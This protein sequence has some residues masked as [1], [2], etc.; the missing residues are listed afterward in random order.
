ME[1]KERERDWKPEE[2][3]N[4]E[5]EE[6]NRLASSSFLRKKE[7]RRRKKNQGANDTLGKT[8]RKIPRCGGVFRRLEKRLYD[9]RSPSRGKI[10]L[11]APLALYVTARIRVNSKARE[12]VRFLFIGKEKRERK[13]G[14]REKKEKWEEKGEAWRD[15]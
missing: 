11:Y 14:G 7:G 15:R 8:E 6:G 13:K 4:R 2:L 5:R 3:T 9:V 12:P 1:R 10:A